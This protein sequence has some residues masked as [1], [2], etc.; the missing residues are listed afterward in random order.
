MQTFQTLPTDVLLHISTYLHTRRRRCALLPYL[1]KSFHANLPTPPLR[2]VITTTLN[3]HLINNANQG[4]SFLRGSDPTKVPEIWIED[5]TFPINLGHLVSNCPYI[6]SIYGE[7]TGKTIL[8]GGITALPFDGTVK[9]KLED[10]TIDGRN[11]VGKHGYALFTHSK[12]TE[13]RAI[14]DHIRIKH[15]NEWKAGEITKVMRD[16]TYDMKFDIPI[17]NPKSNNTSSTSKRLRIKGIQESQIEGGDIGY[18]HSDV[19]FTRVEV[20]HFK[21]GGIYTGSGANVYLNECEIHH[22]ARGAVCLPGGK[23]EIRSTKIYDN[24]I[25]LEARKVVEKKQ[26][27]VDTRNTESRDTESNRGETKNKSQDQNK[28]VRVSPKVKNG[29]ISIDHFTYINTKFT[30]Q[31]RQTIWLPSVK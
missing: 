9:V 15:D 26:P 8:H 3:Q 24:E 14:G 19:R 29:E 23:I 7:G 1:S 28:T 16:G 31:V 10:V 25:S 18:A 21:Y 22:C 2:I 12:Y 5:G 17:D 20:S 27:I 4:A 30:G 6:V 13:K 11:K